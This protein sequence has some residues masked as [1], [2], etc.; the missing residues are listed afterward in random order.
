MEYGSGMWPDVSDPNRSPRGSMSADAPARAL[1][2][3]LLA[4]SACLTAWLL[5]RYGLNV[6]H[7]PA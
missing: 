5:H 7:L 3:G 1:L 6:A 2:T 4:L